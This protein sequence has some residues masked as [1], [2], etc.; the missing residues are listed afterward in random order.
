MPAQQLPKE[1]SDALLANGTGELEVIDPQTQRTYVICDVSLHRN[2]K[3]VLDLEA[4]REGVHQVESG[5]TES[6]EISFEQM[7]DRLGFESTP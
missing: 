1:L 3:R 2:A 5:D 7:R 4:I 6:L